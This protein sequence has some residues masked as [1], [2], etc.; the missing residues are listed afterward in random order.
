M[1]KLIV[2]LMSVLKLLAVGKWYPPASVRDVSTHEFM[3]LKV[4]VIEFNERLGLCERQT[5]AT[6]KKVYREET[7]TGAEEVAKNVIPEIKPEL[8]MRDLIGNLQAGDQVPEGV[9]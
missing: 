6:R 8:S 9:L 2:Y 4:A 3:D 7:R 5:E 1:L